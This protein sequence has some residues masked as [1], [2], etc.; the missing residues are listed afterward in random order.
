M[1]VLLENKV[2][3]QY[4]RQDDQNQPI[5]KSPELFV[6]PMEISDTDK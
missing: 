5:L 2:I 1:D 6:D 4:I 3:E